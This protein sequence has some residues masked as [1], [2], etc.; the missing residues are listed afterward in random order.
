MSTS[1]EQRQLG[2]ILD[3]CFGNRSDICLDVLG[4]F[5]RASIDFILINLPFHFR[6]RKTPSDLD[7]LCNADGYLRAR[8]Y[9]EEHG[10]LRLDRSPGTGQVVYVGYGRDKGFVRIHLHENLQFFGATWMTYER[11]V[12]YTFDDQGVRVADASLDY[13][14]LHLEWF[15]KGKS[16]YPRRIDEVAVLCDKST[17][18]A[19]GKKLF[20]EDYNLIERL[21]HLNRTHVFPTPGCRLRL[22]LGQAGSV[23][24]SLAYLTQ[25]ILLRFDWLYFW[26]R[27][28]TFVVVIGID[29]AGKTTLAQA[30]AA[31][32]DR[33]GLFCQY[34]Y[35]GLKDSLVQRF[36]RMIQPGGDPRE[37]YVGQ[38]GIADSLAKR[39]TF[40]A[41][42]FN[43]VLSMFYIL[44]YII[45]CTVVL[46]PIR[47][48]NDLIIVDRTWL[49]KLMSP[50][51]WGNKLFFHL[52]PKPDLVIA[53]N[54]DLNVFYERTKEFEVPV[55][56]RMQVA[57][58][59]AVV[60]IEA[61]GIEV[62]RLDT[63]QNDVEKCCRLAQEK[64]WDYICD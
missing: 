33:G 54:G 28:G 63:V 46:A 40:V 55:L 9:L 25:R 26:R 56:E 4:T 21:E 5:W 14:I 47:R 41:N 45:K 36:R 34:H 61:Q 3:A 22:V 43:L 50:N 62:M 15:F 20:G 11:A 52:L 57:L 12:E 59:D 6:M 51:R 29:G 30:I 48:H 23:G 58:D 64:L 10:W 16:D 44:E 2:P 42:M 13:F 60:Y 35:L 24:R 19:T 1:V 31:Q 39:S 7:L 38:R 18:V 27:T 8:R 49:D 37:R 53:L 32:H 17:L